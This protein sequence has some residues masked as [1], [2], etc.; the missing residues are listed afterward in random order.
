MAEPPPGR[1]LRQQKPRPLC[2]ADCP[3]G[4]EVLT[5]RKDGER[6][7][8]TWCVVA[9]H[10]PDGRLQVQVPADKDEAEDPLQALSL[11]SLQRVREW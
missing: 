2:L 11:V 10:L 1:P 7:F 4:C 9:A 8:L 5:P 6:D 3:P